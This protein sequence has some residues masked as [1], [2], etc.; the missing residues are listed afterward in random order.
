M[1]YFYVSY[2]LHE[3]YPSYTFLV[4]AKDFKNAGDIAKK[5]IS[6]DY[7]EEWELSKRFYMVEVT[8][9]DLLQRMLIN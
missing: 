7:P 2:E 4:K 5:I 1:K 8:A 6:T 9:E 3:S